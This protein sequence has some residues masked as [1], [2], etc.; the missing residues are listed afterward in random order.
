MHGVVCLVFKPHVIASMP[1]NRPPSSSHLPRL[2][3]AAGALT[4]GLAIGL[5]CSEP[6]AWPI[7]WVAC[8]GMSAA[9]VASAKWSF[10][11]SASVVACAA[12]GWHGAATWWV[13]L[14]VRADGEAV[15]L[16]QAL[17]VLM[18]VV[19]Q[20]AW[21]LACWLPLRWATRSQRHA[22]NT[23]SWR[24]GAAWC[25][26]FAAADTL[27]Q[28][29]W[30]G[31]GYA[32]LGVAMVDAPI[33]GALL[34]M[35]GAQGMG[36]AFMALA[37]SIAVPLLRAAQRHTLAGM[38]IPAAL[39]CTLLLAL[40]SG[41]R[42]WTVSPGTSL[43]AIAL[44]S[45]FD[46][47]MA[48]TEQTSTQAIEALHEAM[49]AAAP[50]SL[51][52]TP[53]TYLAWPP[54]SEPVGAWA[55]LMEH[56]A[57]RK[58]HLLV[59]MPHLAS[60]E[61]GMQ[62][63]NAVVHLAPERQSLYA[64][65]RL[66]PGAEYLPWPQLLEPIYRRVFDQVRRGESPAPPDLTRALFVGGAQIGVSICHEQAFALTMADRAR[67]ASLLLNLSDDSWIPSKAYRAQM[68]ATARVRAMEFGKPL[69]RVTNGGDSSLI[70]PR[71][72]V[73][74]RTQGPAA[75]RVAVAL[76]PRD[77]DTPY[78]AVAAWIAAAP[79]LAS[80]LVFIGVLPRHAPSRL[81]KL[82]RTAS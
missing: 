32:G 61:Q 52:V 68:L 65:E 39:S 10:A 31:N 12:L 70:D 9:V 47:R 78:G 45:N 62:L 72:N 73:V 57:Q 67:G 50:G 5:S 23:A 14:A 8:I 48:W 49:T 75:R 40:V 53:E 29:G 74:V 22:G 16:W 69:L 20:L 33:S 80:A 17:V 3:V 43:Q 7:A 79:L 37:T 1:S 55:A 36:F 13:A 38:A 27:R 59:G 63:M 44:Q 46:K 30:W 54:P 76:V 28:L 6:A 35:I 34:P 64:K 71:G 19:S 82:E 42:E 41:G 11:W 2:L 77:G 26:A 81:S 18:V 25:L 51:I 15:L 66:V 58:V 24:I 60:D 4:C 21:W 56:A